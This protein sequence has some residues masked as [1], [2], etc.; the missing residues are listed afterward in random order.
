M[1]ERTDRSHITPSFYL[2]TTPSNAVT[3]TQRCRA[4]DD[5]EGPGSGDGEESEALVCHESCASCTAPDPDSCIECADEHWRDEEGL[6]GASQRCLPA[7]VCDT[8]WQFEA[9]ALDEAADRVCGVCDD[10]CIPGL[11]C[12]GPGPGGCHSAALVGVGASSI[13]WVVP[14][15]G[16]STTAAT[17]PD[18]ASPIVGVG[19]DYRWNMSAVNGTATSLALVL[20][21]YC[22]M[23]AANV[24]LPAANSS[25]GDGE[26]ALIEIPE[27]VHI[28]DAGD[29]CSGLSTGALASHGV[30]HVLLA[31]GSIRSWDAASGDTTVV[32]DAA[33]GA[34]S[35][36]VAQ[37]P[38]TGEA[39]VLFGT[40]AGAVMRV[41]GGTT[42]TIAAGVG[43]AVS[44]LALDPMRRRVA[45]STENGDIGSVSLDGGLDGR[46]LAS[47]VPPWAGEVAS[48]PSSDVDADVF[49]VA[50]VAGLRSTAEFV[51]FERTVSELSIDTQGPDTGD[52]APIDTLQPGDNMGGW[53][54]A[55]CGIDD[56]DGDSLND[57]VVGLRHY[58]SSESLNAGAVMILRLLA[59]GSPV[60]LRQISSDVGMAVGTSLALPEDSW[61][62][63]SVTGLP[64]WDGDGTPELVVGGGGF[65]GSAGA[66]WVLHLNPAGEAT[67]V[68][69]ISSAE[70]DGQ[71]LS[72]LDHFGQGLATVD[73]LDG[74]GRVELAVGS[75]GSGNGG[76]GRGLVYIVFLRASDAGYRAH[77]TIGEGIQ[78][79]QQFGYACASAVWAG[80]PLLAVSAP[81][82]GS[83]GIGEVGTGAVYLQFFD[84]DA[85]GA[86]VAASYR[87]SA[88]NGNLASP[89][90]LGDSWGSSVA[91][92]GDLDGDGFDELIV[93][94]SR[95]GA[96][97][98]AD[99]VFLTADGSGARDCVRLGQDAPSPLPD[100]VHIEAESLWGASVALVRSGLP[101]GNTG[102]LLAVA[103]PDVSNS[104]GTAFILTVA[105][106]LPRSLDVL[107]KFDDAMFELSAATQGDHASSW[108]PSG[109]VASGDEMGSYGNALC[110][111]DDIDGDGEPDMVIGLRKHDVP[112]FFDVGAVLVTRLLP[113]GTPKLLQM[114]SRDKGLADG[115]SLPLPQGARFGNSIAELPDWDSN[116]V[117][118]LAI[119]AEGTESSLGAVWVLRLTR[120][121]TA[122]S[123]LRIGNS[124]MDGSPLSEADGFGQGLCTIPDLD[125]DSR[126]ELA[127][128]AF[129]DD[130]GGGGRGAVYIVFLRSDDAGYRAHSK[131][132][133]SGATG[134]KSIGGNDAQFFGYAS[135]S[136]RED[137]AHGGL[138]AVGAPLDDDGGKHAGAAY[139]VRLAFGD[140][141]VSVVHNAKLSAFHGGLVDKPI[142]KDEWGISVAFLGD[143]DGDGRSELLVGADRD[144]HYGFADLLFLDA[145]G[146]NARDGIRL[147]NDEVSPLPSTVRSR[148][149]PGSGWAGSVAFLRP[150]S[151][152]SALLLGV[153]AQYSHAGASRG[154]AVFL[155]RLELPRLVSVRV[156]GDNTPAVS[157]QAS[158]VLPLRASPALAVQ[159]RVCHAG[160]GGD[161]LN[162]VAPSGC[163]ACATGFVR[164]SD[165]S[166]ACCPVDAA[167]VNR[168]LYYRL[169]NRSPA[170]S[171]L[172]ALQRDPRNARSGVYTIK[173]D[174]FRPAF[175]VYCD[176]ER[177]GGGWTLLL[178]YA[179]H[180]TPLA[181]PEDFPDID[182]VSDLT[183]GET[184]MYHGSLV[185]FTDVREEVSSGHVT[186]W[187]SHFSL[188]QL[189][190][191][192]RMYGYESRDSVA[193]DDVPPCRSA[194][195][196]ESDSIPRCCGFACNTVDNGIVGWSKIIAPHSSARWCWA[197][198]GQG[199]LE[200]QGSGRCPGE[201][202]GSRLTRVY[203]REPLDA[204]YDKDGD[205]WECGT[206]HVTCA[207]CDGPGAGSC[208]PNRCAAGYWWTGARCL[209]LTPPCDVSSEYEAAAPTSSSDRVCATCHSSCLADVGCGGAGA[210]D[211]KSAALIA[212]GSK[213]LVWVYANGSRTTAALFPSDSTAI[214]GAGLDS[215]DRFGNGT[216]TAVAIT[217]DGS[218]WV[219]NVSTANSFRA[220]VASRFGLQ[221]SGS[222]TVGLATGTLAATGDVYAVQSNGAI[223]RVP[224]YHRNSDPETVVGP[225][226]GAT[227]ATVYVDSSSV[228]S[229]VYGTSAGAV[230]RVYQ[231]TTYTLADTLGA[232]VTSLAVVLESGRVVW[233][234]SDGTAAS[235]S[236]TD[237]SD[238][239]SLAS[240]MREHT[241]SV[242]V[243]STAAGAYEALFVDGVPERKVLSPEDAVTFQDDVVELSAATE[244]D[245]AGH[246]APVGTVATGDHM[247]HGGN[248][249]CSVQDVDGDGLSDMVVGSHQASSVSVLRVLADGS[250][251]LLQRI[252]S[253]TG[254]EAGV[255]L[256]LPSASGFGVSLAGLPDWTDS[257]PSLAV[258]ADG[259]DSSTGEVW[260]LR[261]TSS[262]T[263]A[264]AARIG[265][266][267]L[268]GSLSSGVKFGSSMCAIP[269]VDGDGHVELAVGA[270]YDGAAD[271]TRGALFI[272]FLHGADGGYRTHSKI[273]E[274][275]GS[276]WN[277]P[278]GHDG[279]L[280]GSAA[281]ATW[282]Y[283]SPLLAVG[284]NQDDAGGADAGAAY[285][286]LLDSTAGDGSVSSYGKLSASDGNLANLPAAGD[287]WGSSVAFVGDLDGDHVTELLVGASHN[288]D[289][290]FVDVVFLATDELSA[291]A[292]IRL[293]AD[294]SS[295][296]PS[297]ARATISTGVRWGSCVSVIRTGNSTQSTTLAITAPLANSGSVA[298]GGIVYLL[299]LNIHPAPG[300]ASYVKFAPDVTEL[301]SATQGDDAESWAPASTVTAG[302]QMG[303]WGNALC[304]MDDVDGDGLRDM[305]VGVHRDSGFVG[306][307][308]VLRLLSDG[309]PRLLQRIAP[310]AGL[311]EG[312]TI[313]SG[314]SDTF[315]ASV[316]ALPDWDGDGVPELAVGQPRAEGR[317]RVWVLRLASTGVAKAASR[318]DNSEMDGAPLADGDSFGLGLA[319]VGDI[320]GDG[321]T[322]LAA[323]AYTSSDGGSSHGAVYIVFLRPTDAGYRAHTRIESSPITSG[324]SQLFG[325]SI[326][327]V[328]L[329]DAPLLA[330]GAY[331]D[332]SVGAG[333]GAVY[334]LAVDS[335]AR[336]GSV[337]ASGKLGVGSG[338]LAR[339][340]VAADNWGTSVAFVSDLDGDGLEELM[341]GARHP[342]E[343]GFVDVLFLAGDGLS[344]RDGVRLGT[345]TASPLP[346]AAKLRLSAGTRWGGSVAH[347]RDEA[348]GDILL[349]VAAPF[350]S[351]SGSS[352][353]GAV[354]LLRLTRP[355]LSRV[356]V[357]DDVGTA[358][359]AGLPITATAPVAAASRVCGAGCTG[360][361]LHDNCNAEAPCSTGYVR[362]D[363]YCCLVGQSCAPGAS[364]AIPVSNSH[365]HARTLAWTADGDSG[366]PVAYIGGPYFEGVLL[367][368]EE[369]TG[370][371]TSLSGDE[372]AVAA[373]WAD[374]DLT[375]A[376]A[377]LV[378][379]YNAPNRLYDVSDGDVVEQGALRGFD[380]SGPAF[381]LAVGDC[382]GDRDV[383]VYVT[384]T[385]GW[386]NLLLINGGT[387]V[388]AS[389][390]NARGAADSDNDGGA[391]AWFE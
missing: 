357:A 381:A 354:F 297:A 352:E 139:L 117:P 190:T 213:A 81:N 173:P 94:A 6:V 112:G 375:G 192:R 26:G 380:D 308:L 157:P 7:T 245:V 240:E 41:E 22:S 50:G 378:A 218:L 161:C 261:L 273:S 255:S 298:A 353:S 178:V 249:V 314:V 191:I 279:Q 328:L 295:P 12:S 133:D 281:A 242:S 366:E 257:G 32:I 285:L 96:A 364:D 70:M 74:D 163:D 28:G 162:G 188:E 57:M 383:D 100:G 305:A 359:V 15:K 229:L 200:K 271:S 29:R 55:L 2:N 196:D 18:G 99:I 189:D 236:L 140:G 227:A 252:T 82:D 258:G 62:G 301:S 122:S 302:S 315:G 184:F 35:I 358:A 373:V 34:S 341:V 361:C 174:P 181:T 171:C 329:G 154:G 207:A 226:S 106:Q 153:A 52:W 230:V 377:L 69:R 272:L 300:A 362:T 39:V 98:Y 187:G 182:A 313:L 239:R 202:D 79:H 101:P 172:Q 307:V 296:L 185:S 197:G 371:E 145:E 9:Q 108:A 121:G 367:R 323:G 73:D 87:F 299:Q 125:G 141:E 166:N 350:D 220:G 233:A 326:S 27:A 289:L 71:P 43:A 134:W 61:F 223:V 222:P 68:A 278:D 330:V 219:A 214:V 203:F 92:I 24:A 382:D 114:I 183:G 46:A 349:G 201:A 84:L 137:S 241:G 303:A 91:F 107:I 269:D 104:T 135:S 89:P 332:A 14:G 351:S 47:S 386:D 198:R 292:G 368:G 11:G 88:T 282:W 370:P 159:S 246:W 142:T 10:A 356:S 156:S 266:T 180:Q 115:V 372:G 306:A 208:L 234:L 251:Q 334:M 340:P 143:L 136:T 342:N 151:A 179:K 118:E 58:D 336:D 21:D 232:D 318:I 316:A 322:E 158:A 165:G 152:G 63:E 77:A 160:C 237:G 195:A 155:I 346:L 4:A 97:G 254:L 8:V 67:A 344:A 127:V 5:G 270:P 320:D 244:G 86:D 148:M 325:V 33:S 90:A 210:G 355:R 76:D 385:A 177:D 206:C 384:Q 168:P 85:G 102:A 293:S 283:G 146:V 3:G 324:G 304:A 331:G 1:C 256:P 287:F 209:P 259:V 338:N 111:V 211:C 131:I 309:S 277:V 167:D 225:G 193:M 228:V 217:A 310:D 247:G 120:E 53:G 199:H 59:D 40:R 45:W 116:D 221:L 23:F 321:S 36:A 119:G 95:P 268:G 16:T 149:D 345:E 54:N 25:V 264:A 19:V 49:A 267:V 42:V 284:A 388:F 212:V 235:A 51:R 263:V 20:D 335:E 369:L 110:G 243:V 60:L 176:M 75:Y 260:L 387:G 126:V 288:G 147:S 113:S 365:L 31:D 348:S 109:T 276:V 374:V 30:A 333:T 124:E 128:G 72:S 360:D 262:G 103:A 169:V 337:A 339:E 376:P 66:V 129:G 164:T 250:A 80:V 93:G 65:D 17:L 343:D 83:G 48:V 204:V 248:A 215:R 391:V 44:G 294:I 224:L 280:F 123:A 319:A 265:N 363:G 286:L 389:T 347:L 317:G 78:D 186:V 130:D 64:D 132:S 390:R 216:L 253:D 231:G 144:I 312:V 194:Y 105:N 238:I 205:D 38:D 138:L 150:E 13:A 290:G 327:S 170:V 311:V 37:M 379:R 291:R 275:S 56:V 175:D 274:S